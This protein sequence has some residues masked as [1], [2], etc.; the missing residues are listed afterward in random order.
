[1][2]SRWLLSYYSKW[3]GGGKHAADTLISWWFR[4]RS[5]DHL[6]ASIEGT[7]FMSMTVV[8]TFVMILTYCS[9]I[10]PI[11]G[12]CDW[13]CCYHVPFIPLFHFYLKIPVRL[14]QDNLNFIDNH[15]VPHCREFYLFNLA[16]CL[17]TRHPRCVM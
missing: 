10:R 17:D 16:Y 2:N 14:Q 12:D 1:M 3:T 6:T 9:H 11:N 7:G 4:V 15:T 13:T 8:L 5:V